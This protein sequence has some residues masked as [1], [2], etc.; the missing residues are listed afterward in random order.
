LIDNDSDLVSFLQPALEG[1]GHRVDVAYRG[2]DGEYL[3]ALNPYD[4]LLLDCLLPDKDGR[5][6]CRDLRGLGITTPALLI[7]ARDTTADKILG[8]NSG[9][10]EYLTKPFDFNELLARVRALGRRKQPPQLCSVDVADLQINPSTRRVSRAD[11]EITLTAKEYKLLE[12]LA[13]RAGRIVARVEIVESVWGALQD[14]TANNVDVLVKHLRDKIDRNFEPR[15]IRTVRS[16]GY[17]IQIQP[18]QP[19]TLSTALSETT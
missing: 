17:T 16:L 11:R 3:A 6:V 13:R 5:Q 7:S 12:L 10:D 9:A 1:E 2:V 15:L 14:S 18:K 8:F 4:V 19:R